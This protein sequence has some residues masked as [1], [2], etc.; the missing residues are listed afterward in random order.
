MCTLVQYEFVNV[1]L[2]STQRRYASA[3][4]AVVA[5]LSVCPFVCLH[6]RHKPALYRKR[7]NI[8]SRK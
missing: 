5:C 1:Q 8:G 7:L 6:V 3:L 2:I 4:H